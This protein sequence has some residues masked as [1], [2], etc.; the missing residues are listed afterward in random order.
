MIPKSI[1]SGSFRILGVDVKCHVLN[2]GQRIIEAES[3]EAVMKAMA[4]PTTTIDEAEIQAFA[5]WRM[6][7]PSDAKRT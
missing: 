7:V 4:D 2:N 3:L 1:W 5:R 6:G